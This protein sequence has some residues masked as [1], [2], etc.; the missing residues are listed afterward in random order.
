M[1]QWIKSLFGDTKTTAQAQLGGQGNTQNINSG[2]IT[3]QNDVLPESYLEIECS[4]KEMLDVQVNE[5]CDKLGHSDGLERLKRS[6]FRCIYPYLLERN[7]ARASN[8][9]QYLSNTSRIKF[10]RLMLATGQ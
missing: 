9:K 10:D 2:N 6:S 4:L 5:W 7:N 3:I 8:M 1:W